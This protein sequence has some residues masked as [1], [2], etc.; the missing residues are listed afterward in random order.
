VV[1]A[2]VLLGLD[3]GTTSVKAAVVGLDGA[4]IAHGRAP[5]AWRRVPTGAEAD[6]EAFVD[7]AREAALAALEAAGPARVLGVGVASMAETGALLDGHGRPVVPAIAW[8]DARGDAEA[9]ALAAELPDAPARTGLP[10]RP[11]STAVKYRWLRANLPESRRGVRWLSVGEWVVRRLGGEEV[12]EL[13]LASRTGWLDVHERGWWEPAL[14]WSEVPPG[15]LPA[16]A[17]A[18]TP[19]G[20]VD[21][22]LPGAEGAVLTVG[23]H[24]HLSA[25]VGAGAVGEDDVLDSCGTAEAFIRTARPLAPASVAEAVAID[26]NVGCHAVEG[27]HCLLAASRSGAALERLLRLLGIPPE[28]RNALEREA[29]EVPPEAG[30]IRVG[31]LNAQRVE[32]TGIGA[33]AS[34][35]VLWRAALECVGESGAEI[36]GRMERVAGPARRLVVAGGWAE[37]PAARVVKTRHLGSFEPTGAITMGARGAALTAGAAAGLWRSGEGPAASA[38]PLASLS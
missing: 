25:A 36:L 37:G 9:S 30:G 13:S 16:P 7:A 33:D 20:R 2:E 21:G 31:G 29:L 22:A 38:P 4:E 10:P 15:L 28:G 35:A 26:V 17:V 11:L 14:A 27:R 32:I 34:P 24:D 8:H 19:A 5:L 12:A 23:G 1:S 6:P 18:G 3:V